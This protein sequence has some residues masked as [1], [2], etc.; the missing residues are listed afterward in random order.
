M[1]SVVVI[2]KDEESLDDTLAALTKQVD[3]L[4]EPVEVVVVDASAG[5]LDHIRRRHSDTVHWLDFQPLQ[6]VRVTIPH[7]RNL[8]VRKAQG[9]VIVF[10]DAG[11]MPSDGWLARMTS[12]LRLGESAVAGT[13]R[14]MSGELVFPSEHIIRLEQ[15]GDV[16]YLTECPTLNFAFTRAAYDALGGFDESF[17]YG[18]D[19]DF[20][21]RLNDSGYKVRYV[22]D[23]SIEHDYGAS[24]RQRR[25]S[26][27]YG[28]ARARL[29][30]K[31]RT[32]RRDILRNDPMVIAYPLFLL[33]LPLTLIFP[34]YPLLLLIPAWRN[35]SD[36]IIRVLV[37]HLW[38]GAGVLAEVAGR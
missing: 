1:I 14:D 28:K 7:Q 2:S 13:S 22:P 5:R 34:L 38:F 31:H 15:I 16:S 26:Y 17:A 32:R 11:C 37:D 25:R 29:Y 23:A 35:R 8:G 9:E 30:K 36:G 27:I 4:D 10:T 19:V 20:T 21:W 18:S 3:G 12:P 6:D 33:G 24:R